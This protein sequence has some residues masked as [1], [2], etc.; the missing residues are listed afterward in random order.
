MFEELKNRIRVD[1]SEFPRMKVYI[2]GNGMSKDGES[3][4]EMYLCDLENETVKKEII[5]ELYK[6]YKKETSTEKT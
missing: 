2:K 6:I 3:D 5:K 4:T 1:F